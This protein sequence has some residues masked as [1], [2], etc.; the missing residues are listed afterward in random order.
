MSNIPVEEMPQNEKNS[1]VSFNVETN[2]EQEDLDISSASVSTTEPSF[3]EMKKKITP[4]RETWSKKLDFLL[5]CVG[6]AV[7]LGNVWR[8]PYLCYKNGGGNK[9]IFTAH[10]YVTKLT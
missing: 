1:L 9:R 8:F 10:I 5:A 3:D 4:D 2:V 7:G 6:F